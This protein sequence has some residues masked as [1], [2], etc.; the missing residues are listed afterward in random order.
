MLELFNM[1]NISTGI[2]YRPA[3]YLRPQYPKCFHF[4]QKK[5]LPY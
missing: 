5:Y 1:D 3:R 2:I 4:L